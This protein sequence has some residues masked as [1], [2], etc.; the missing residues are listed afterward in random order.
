MCFYVNELAGFLIIL[1]AFKATLKVKNGITIK[2]ISD[3][4]RNS[5]FRV[6]LIDLLSVFSYSFLLY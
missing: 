6:N 1:N 3:M 5:V 2:K 4:E